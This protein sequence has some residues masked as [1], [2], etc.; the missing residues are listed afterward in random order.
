[1]IRVELKS[2]INFSEPPYTSIVNRASYFSKIRRWASNKNF[3]FDY[4]N[5]HS[6]FPTAIIFYNDEDALAFMLTFQVR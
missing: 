5:A 1:M 2:L 6:Y 4:T 3:K